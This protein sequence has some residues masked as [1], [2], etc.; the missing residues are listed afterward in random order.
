MSLFAPSMAWNNHSYL[1]VYT[2][3]KTTK[4]GLDYHSYL[5]VCNI[6]NHKIWPGVSFSLSIAYNTQKKKKV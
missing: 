1:V 6:Q 2:I 5:V 4:H 3:H